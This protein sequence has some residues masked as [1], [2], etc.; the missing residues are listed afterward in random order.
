MTALCAPLMI[1]NL[2]RAVLTLQQKTAAPQQRNAMTTT[3]APQTPAKPEPA[4]APIRRS[5]VMTEA[6]APLITAH[7]QPGVPLRP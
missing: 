1:A 4:H 7:L 6:P 3:H 5:F 2:P